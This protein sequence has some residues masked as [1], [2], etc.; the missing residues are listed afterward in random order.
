[1]AEPL[2]TRRLL[3]YGVLGL[4]LA[5]AGLPVYVHVPKFYAENMQVNLAA[6]GSVLLIIRLFDAVLDP[7]IGVMS[8]RF[9]HRVKTI[10]AIAALVLAAAYVALFHPPALMQ[11]PVVWLI[12]C[13]TVV[14]ISFSTLMINYYALGVDMADSYNDH[15]RVA[16]FRESSMLIGVLLA[17]ML[18]AILVAQFPVREAYLI[19]S[20]ALAP[21]LVVCAW[22]CLSGATIR[23]RSNIDSAP[24]FLQLLASSDVRWVLFIGFCNAIPTAI[25]ST[26]FMFFTGDI[27]HAEHYSGPMLAIYFLSAAFGMPVWTRLS[28]RYGKKY[29]L[30]CAMAVAIVCFIWAWGLHAGDVMPF[31]IICVLSGLT[32]GADSMLMPSMLADALQNRREATATGFGLWNLNIKLTMAFAAG[33]A[34]PLLSAGGYTPGAINSEDALRRLSLCY[35]CLP[36]VFKAFALGMLYLS[37]LDKR[38]PV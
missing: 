21:L 15:T 35:A 27:L 38:R 16:A 4:P 37:P 20:L 6:L 26:L 14:Y 22:L 36:C 13:L 11:Y 18:P 24:S 9:H 28:S 1:M 19:F 33:I 29:S 7:I 12:G 10:M 8:D 2:Q 23:Q 30:M 34:L 32:V 17:S 3:R 31:I 5:F 25:T